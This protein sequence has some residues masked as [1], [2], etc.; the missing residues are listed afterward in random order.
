MRYSNKVKGTSSQNPFSDSQARNF[1]DQKVFH[2]F[3]PISLFWTLFNDQHEVLLGTRGSGKTFLLK[4]MRYSMLKRIDND[5]AK[6]LVSEKKYLA[7]Y[8]PMHLEFVVPFNNSK[9]TEDQVVHFFQ[10]AFNCLLSESLI[11]E[12]KSLI[13]DIEGEEEQIFAQINIAN[14]LNELWF[15]DDTESCDLDELTNKIRKVYFGIDWENLN[16]TKAPAVFRRQ[17]CSPLV[18]AQKSIIK[19]LHLKEEPTWIV[20]VDEA[21]FLND[22][23][24]RCINGVFRSDSNRI[25]LKIATLP[26]YHTTLKTLDDGID[27]TDGNDFNYT[28]VD[29]AYD[30]LDFIELT[31]SLCKHRLH[32]RFSKEDYCETLDDFVGV[33]GNDEYIDYYRKEV[34]NEKGSYKAIMDDIKSSFSEIR[35]RGSRN[36]SN[37]RKEIF[38]KFAPVFY[39]RVMKDLSET[40]NHKPGWY[41]GPKM[42]RRLSQG[43]P[44]F[45]IQIMSELFEKAKT[46]E[47]TPK[48][49]H[50]VLYDFAEN[51]CGSTKALEENGPKVYK[52]LALIANKL[53]DKVHG[54]YL[55][56]GGNTFTVKYKNIAAFPEEK[57][58]LELAVAYSRIIV[59]E[60]AKKNGLSLSTKYSLGNAYS[61]KYWIPMRSDAT[62][63]VSLDENVNNEYD[64]KEIKK[65]KTSRT[66]KSIETVTDS[67]TYHQLGLE[68]V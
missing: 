35:K 33:E 62:V 20:C 52:N 41:A 15:G 18:A 66:V 59:D 42:I 5:I 12:V 28:I 29:M 13:D 7:L 31:N 63:A 68:E 47:L 30:D 1:S 3:Y 44:R 16:E 61:M 64:V 25:A 60:K 51:I 55:V 40:G 49:Q 39:V 46:T 10:I 57:K 36:Y 24:Q 6:S 21:E 32:D 56:A 48:A 43:N 67:E 54:P 2:E 37:E 11:A 65:K 9:L 27:V 22:T 53:S 19:Y 4:M 17:I 58:W 26:F 8:V 14:S 45:F 50:Q 34:G 38:D 23:L